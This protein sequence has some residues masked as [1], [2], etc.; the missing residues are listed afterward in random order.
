[1]FAAIPTNEVEDD[2]SWASIIRTASVD[3]V[4]KSAL[5]VFRTIVFIVCFTILV[6]KQWDVDAK[7]STESGGAHGRNKNKPNDQLE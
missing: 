3:R 7:N 4:I 2:F 6:T 1:M 5:F